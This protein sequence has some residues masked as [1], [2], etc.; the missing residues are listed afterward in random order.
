M[1][2]FF[3]WKEWKSINSRLHCQNKGEEEGQEGEDSKPQVCKVCILIDHMRK[4]C[5]NLYHP[6]ADIAYN[7][8]SLLMSCSSELKKQL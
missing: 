4:R 2:S 3:T 8:I 6:C 7:E 5:C 1:R